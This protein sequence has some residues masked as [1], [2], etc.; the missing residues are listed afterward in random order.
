MA[1]GKASMPKWQRAP[2]ELKR[3]FEEAVRPLAGAEIRQMFGYPAAFVNG[4]MFAGVHQDQMILR[5]APDDRAAIG[6]A[7]FEPMAGRPMCEYVV[8]PEAIRE[9]P[10][11]LSGWLE[12]ALAYTAGLPPKAA[13]PKRRKGAA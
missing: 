5:L 8:V 10:A 11:E 3:T 6:G 12:R 9:T 1:N 4:Q 2:E 7:A 13:K